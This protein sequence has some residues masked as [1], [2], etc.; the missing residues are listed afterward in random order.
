MFMFQN[1]VVNVDDQLN[2]IILFSSFLNLFI[3]I[4][5]I[6]IFSLDFMHVGI[7]ECFVDLESP[8]YLDISGRD[9]VVECKLVWVSRIVKS[10][11]YSILQVRES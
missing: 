4:N 5:G 3:I 2:G 11:D 1:S 10:S 6:I 9:R 7:Y 8:L